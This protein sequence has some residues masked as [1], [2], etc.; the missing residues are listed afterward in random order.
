MFDPT[1]T[2]H[3]S[4][5]TKIV[6]LRITLGSVEKRN[7]LGRHNRFKNVYVHLKFAIFTA[8]DVIIKVATEFEIA[9]ARFKH[10]VHDPNISKILESAVLQ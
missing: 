10:L 6:S 9:P 3:E 4:K 2:L 7:S 5:V 8:I 1:L